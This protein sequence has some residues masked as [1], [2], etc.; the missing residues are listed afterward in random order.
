MYKTRLPGADVTALETLIG[1]TLKLFGYPCSGR[2]SPIPDRL[3]AQFI[4]SDTVTNP[5]N[6]AYRRWPE[7]WRKE[8]RD[9]RVWDPADRSSLLWGVN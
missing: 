1:D 8:R 5:V 9:R 2:R 7:N 3:A 6:V 4:E